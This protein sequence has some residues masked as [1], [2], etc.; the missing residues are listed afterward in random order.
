MCA[1]QE[2]PGIVVGEN[3]FALFWRTLPWDH[4]PGTLFLTEAGG[5]V[6]RLDGSEYRAVE[7]DRPG[8]LAAASPEIWHSVREVL[9]PPESH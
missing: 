3:D 6:A 4:V 9:L 5:M 2:Y 1:G 8:L 7:H